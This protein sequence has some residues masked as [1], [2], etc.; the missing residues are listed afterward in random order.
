L[1]QAWQEVSDII[2]RMPIQAG[3]ETLLVKVMCNQTNAPAKDKQS[4]ENTHAEIVFGL[5][6]SEGAAVAHQVNEAHGDTTID[7]E[8]QVVFL[9]SSDSLDGDGVIKHLTAWKALLDEFFYKLNAQIRVVAGLDFVADA[10]DC[11]R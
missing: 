4:V 10:G 3:S 6:R 9:A 11:S 1:S 5:F 8:N 7:I 2:P